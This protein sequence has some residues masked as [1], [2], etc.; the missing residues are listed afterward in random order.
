MGGL[1]GAGSGYYTVTMLP[2]YISIRG[3][4]PASRP[5]D[6]LNPSSLRRRHGPWLGM[7][8]A[9]QS[10]GVEPPSPLIDE[11]LFRL[12]MVFSIWHY[13]P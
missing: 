8:E 10:R 12:A 6:D 7:V 1:S 2:V 5:H 4:L 13:I 11:Q 9:G 3:Q